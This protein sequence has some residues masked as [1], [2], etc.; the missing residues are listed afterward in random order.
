MLR[1]FVYCHTVVTIGIDAEIADRRAHKQ[2][3]N[4]KSKPRHSEL[5]PQIR[6]V[7]APP[8]TI[9]PDRIA[10][11]IES[12]RD[13]AAIVSIFAAAGV[14]RTNHGYLLLLLQLHRS[15]DPVRRIGRHVD[16]GDRRQQHQQQQRV[17]ID[18]A[19]AG[20]L[21]ARDQFRGLFRRGGLPAPGGSPAA[22]ETSPGNR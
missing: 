15:Q 10:N 20:L 1:G 19:V 4:T 21:D 22:A 14:E 8:K 16:D 12:E 13:A 2:S 6:F 18:L 7:D 11:R 9:Q 3:E 17:R 5:I